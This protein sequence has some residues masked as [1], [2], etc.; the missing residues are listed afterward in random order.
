ME[1]VLAC[2]HLWRR[3][4]ATKIAFRNGKTAP[5]FPSPEHIYLEQW[6][7]LR[8]SL[9][10]KQVKYLHAK[11]KFAILV[12]SRAIRAWKGLMK[13]ILGNKEYEDAVKAKKTVAIEFYELHVKKRIVYAWNQVARNHRRDLRRIKRCYLAWFRW[14]RAAKKHRICAKQVQMM[15]QVRNRKKT[16]KIMAALTHSILQR[17]LTSLRINAF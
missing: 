7:I 4:I 17:Y 16:L 3:Y 10:V 1:I 14:S 13:G 12:Q 2:F 11:E 6:V 8:T 5:V 9:I 15:M